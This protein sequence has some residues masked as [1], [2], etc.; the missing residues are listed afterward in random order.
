MRSSFCATLPDDAIITFTGKAFSASN[1]CPED[2]SVDDIAHALS[3]IPR[4]L[5]H[6]EAFFSVAQH[7]LLVS[8]MLIT[9][10]WRLSGLL[11]DAA[12]AY[13]GDLP[14]PIKHLPE[15]QGYRDA[16]A[17]IM[18]AIAKKF[19]V[20]V[21]ASVVKA[22]DLRALAAEAELNNPYFQWAALREDVEAAMAILPMQPKEAEQAFLSAFSA[23]GGVA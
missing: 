2:L 5:G 23:C 14:G 10:R 8:G 3:R 16:E 1:P 9:R 22:A 19:G 21:G 7:S 17:R 18:R 11:H 12:E 13:L 20:S 6:G 4:F 15:M